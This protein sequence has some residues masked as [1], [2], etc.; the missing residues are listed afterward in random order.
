ML[1]K[2]VSAKR[3]AGVAAIA[4]NGVWASQKEESWPKVKSYIN[5]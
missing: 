3:Y 4:T 5:V 1:E 2:D